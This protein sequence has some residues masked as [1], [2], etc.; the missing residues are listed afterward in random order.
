MSKF[1][2][3]LWSLAILCILV[4]TVV[5]SMGIILVGAIGLSLYGVYRHYFTKKATSEY[6]IRPYVSGEIIDIKPK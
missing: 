5:F 2:R 3:I 1:Y 6:T 4:T